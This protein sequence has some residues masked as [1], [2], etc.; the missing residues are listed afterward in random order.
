[1]KK[2][3]ESGVSFIKQEMDR[4][5]KL[6]QGKLSDKKKTE[7]QSRLNIIRSFNVALKDEL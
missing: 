4:V 5:N 6:L 3:I 1:M 7:L 2:V